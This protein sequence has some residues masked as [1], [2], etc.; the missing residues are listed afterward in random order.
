MSSRW[1]LVC[2]T[3]LVLI[4][5]ATAQTDTLTPTAPTAVAPPSTKGK[6]EVGTF[7]FNVDGM[8]KSVLPG[9]DF[10]RYAGGKWVDTTEIPPDRSSLGSVSV[11]KEKASRA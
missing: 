8:D 5:S 9:D 6:P 4:V 3:A 7:G 2:S 10:V 11:I 1:L